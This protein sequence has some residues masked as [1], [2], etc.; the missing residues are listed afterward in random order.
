[1]MMDKFARIFTPVIIFI[2]LIVGYYI[3]YSFII[4]ESGGWN[5]LAIIMLMPFLIVL[6]V[7]DIILKVI[8]SIKTYVIWIVELLLIAAS[9]AFFWFV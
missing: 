9:I 1:M 5:M 3:F 2:L 4:D 7:L 6:F 8:K